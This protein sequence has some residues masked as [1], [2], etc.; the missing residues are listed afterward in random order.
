M[1]INEISASFKDPSGFVFS[2]D[3]KIYRQI[4][5]S[6]KENYDLL[7]KSGLY[8]KLVSLGYLIPHKE[9]K[10]ANC[11]SLNAYQIIQPQKIPFIS[12]PYEWCFGMLKAAALLTLNIQKTALDCN[13]SL[14]DASAFNIQ[15]LEGKPILI[16]TLSFEK[17][18]EGKP[19]IAYKQFAE[20]F[21]APLALMSL[22][23]IRLN[24][25]SAL[26][27][28][29]IPVDLASRLLPFR[30]RFKLS[31]LFHI[32]VH[33]SSQ[34]R[35]SQTKLTDTQMKH[36]FSYRALSGLLD[37]L[38][39]AIK[40]LKWNPKKTQWADYYEE[41]NNYNNEALKQKAELTGEF[42]KSI[43]PKTVWD[44][45]A[46]TGFFS[47]IAAET[48]ALAISFD[49]DLGALEKNYLETA[50]NQE[51]NILPLF[52]DLT[53]PNPALGWANQERSSLFQRGPADVILALALIHHLAIAQ[54]IPLSYIASLFSGLGKYLI[55][56]FVP[57]EDP[58]VKKLLANREDIFPNY[59]Q[60]DFEKIFKEFFKIKRICPID[61]SQR[62]LYLMEKQKNE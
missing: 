24:R 53:N 9:V 2:L 20:H 27:L 3:G 37:S 55:I 19:W 17:Y 8:D 42:L 56:E 52:C 15:F 13:M 59:T 32:H 47:R 35:F 28:D 45:G 18:E 5:K 38:E 34:K 44:M 22:T 41:N 6:Y 23:D 43:K 4:N 48:K 25:L 50:S 16:D 46:N 40:G 1:K 57:K 51:K 29:G 7:V 61:K 60:E 36:S 11:Q 49:A 58:Q 54:N 62:I 39:G 26:F 30:S 31:L 33:S 12:Y 10:L 14:K 21:L